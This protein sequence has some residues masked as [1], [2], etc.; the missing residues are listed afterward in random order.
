[1]ITT[2]TSLTSSPPTSPPFTSLS[3]DSAGTNHDSLPNFI[4]PFS[5]T[6]T[7]EDIDYLH[8]K[9]ALDIPPPR[10]LNALL[11]AYIQYVYPYMPAT[12][13][14][15]IRQIIAGKD[16]SISILLL[17]AIAFAGVPFVDKDKIHE[18]GFDSRRSC[19]KAFYDKSKVGGAPKVTM[20]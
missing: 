2:P 20:Q 14:S 15:S 13:L 3:I 8:L 7:R 5:D 16:A 18:A 17:Q 6:I 4:K 1:M 10:I 9:G 12:D 11:S 19:R